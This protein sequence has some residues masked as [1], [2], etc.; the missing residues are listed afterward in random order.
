MIEVIKSLCI[1]LFIR[2]NGGWDAFEMVPSKEVQ[3]DTKLK[4]R[5]TEEDERK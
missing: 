2:A 4:A 3:C 1:N 5:M